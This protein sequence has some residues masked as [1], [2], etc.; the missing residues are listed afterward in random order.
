MH[1]AKVSRFNGIVNSKMLIFLLCFL[2]TVPLHLEL[3]EMVL[4]I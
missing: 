4:S 2:K 1:I 3:I